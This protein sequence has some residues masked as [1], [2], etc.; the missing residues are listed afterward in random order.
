[1]P[2]PT[3]LK[4]QFA[5]VF[6]EMDAR[7]RPLKLTLAGVDGMT[8]DLVDGEPVFSDGAEQAKASFRR[9][10]LAE[11]EVPL[12]LRSGMKLRLLPTSGNRVKV[13]VG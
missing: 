13:R 8:L 1:M 6:V 10:W 9:R 2:T 4:A 11:H 3:E 12:V 7:P 5:A